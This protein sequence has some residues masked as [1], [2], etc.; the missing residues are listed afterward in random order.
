MKHS[1]LIKDMTGKRFG[2]LKVIEYVGSDKRGIALWKC[3]CEC[4]GEKNVKGILLR[5]KITKSCGCL[6]TMHGYGT[7]KN[8]K[9]QTMYT[10]WNSMKQRCLNP[11]HSAYKSYGGRGITIC[12][13]W[14][15]F[16]NYLND[17]VK[18]IGSLPGPEFSLDRID[19][20]KGYE[21]GNL[22][23]A[24]S[25]KQ[26]NNKRCEHKGVKEKRERFERKMERIKNIMGKRFERLIAI[27]PTTERIHRNVVWLF[28]CD[29]GNVKKIAIN[30]VLTG[31]T[32]GC[33]CSQNKRRLENEKN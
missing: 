30:Q 22:R 27:A 4:G 12:K 8:G 2:K 11:K 6:R 33:G 15:S 28:K 32:T 7:L 18:E 23:W 1:K 16:D 10:R 20:D 29:C 14:L 31:K 21:P 19:N 25:E 26:N 24:T 17:I 5:N 13:E 9:R 3:A